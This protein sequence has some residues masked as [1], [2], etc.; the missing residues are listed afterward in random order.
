MPKFKLSNRITSIFVIIGFGT[1]NF[2]TGHDLEGL[3]AERLIA[4]ST[5]PLKNPGSSAGV[6]FFNSSRLSDQ[7]RSALKSIQDQEHALVIASALLNEASSKIYNLNQ[8]DKKKIESVILRAKTWNPGTNLKVCFYEEG[9]ERAKSAI[10]KHAE[11]WADHGNIKFD[12]G[13]A[14]RF[15]NC[16]SDE[17]SNI[18][19]T[20]RSSGYWSLLGVDSMYDSSTPSV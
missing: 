3:R 20:F 15:R 13:K 14:P 19:I 7:T 8:A 6:N 2:A 4:A 5:T 12:F 9:G 18:R 1:A 16:S 11:E 17:R 10:V